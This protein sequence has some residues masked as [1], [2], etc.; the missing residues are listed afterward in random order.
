MPLTVSDLD[1]L[2]AYFTG[3]MDRTHHAPNVDAIALALLGAVLW[4][5]DD[6]AP[7]EVRTYA[8]S[9]ANVLWV[10]IAGQ[11]YALAYNHRE[12]CIELR[13]RTTT[14]GARFSFTN[15]TPVTEVRRIF[16]ELK[17]T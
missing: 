2:I 5:K 7:I 15:K 1:T 17:P 4:K 8:G 9:P 13:E 3:V 12:G 10:Q 6:D 11:R 14:G 16:E